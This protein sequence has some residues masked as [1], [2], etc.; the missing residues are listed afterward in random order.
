ML[1]DDRPERRSDRGR[2]RNAPERGEGQE[3]GK[4]SNGEWL[5]RKYAANIQPTAGKP[6]ASTT[7][8][9]FPA[10]EAA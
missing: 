8:G 5:V 4:W 3:S 6:T 7:R 9:V 1:R 2:P 10:S